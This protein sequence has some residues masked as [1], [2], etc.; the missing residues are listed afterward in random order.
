MYR[1]TGIEWAVGCWASS[2]VYLL[3]NLFKKPV[4]NTVSHFSCYLMY[5]DRHDVANSVDPDQTA[6]KG[7][8]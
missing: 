8:V 2:K 5:L 1:R 6:P 4:H 3:V 7:A